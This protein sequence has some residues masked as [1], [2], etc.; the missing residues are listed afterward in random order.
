MQKLEKFHLGLYDVK[1]QFKRYVYDRSQKA[2]ESGDRDRDAVDTVEALQSRQAFMRDKWIESVGGLPDSDHPLNSQ[3]TGSVQGDG[4]RIDK[5]IFESRPST[6]VTC[7]L[8][9]PDGITKPR[10][11]VMFLC[12]HADNAKQYDRYQGVCQRLVAEGLIVLAVDP[13]GQGER[14]SYYDPA[15]GKPEIPAGTGEHDYAGSQCLPLGDG[16]ARY[17]VHD[18]MRA[19]DY[20][21]TLPQVDQARIGVTGNSG[22]GTQTSMLMLCEPRIAA[23]AP[24]TFI[25]NRETYMY[26][27]QAQD[28]EQVWRGM[29]RWGFDHEDIVLAMAPRPVLVLGVT[30]DFFP[31]E[32]TRRTVERTRRFWEMHGIADMPVLEEDRSTHQY[33][34]PLADKAAAFFARHLLTA[35]ERREAAEPVLQPFPQEELN[36]TRSGQVRGDYPDARAVFEE[37]VERLRQLEERLADQPDERRRKEALA[38]LRERVEGSRIATEL[39]PRHLTFP[40]TDGLF[41]ESYIWWSQPGI[42]N[43]GFYFRSPAFVGKKLPVTIALWEQGTR[44]LA[45]KADWIRATCEGGRAVLVL[46]V[47]ADGLCTPHPIN[48]IPLWNWYGTLHKLTAD[49]FWLDDSLAA[50]RVHDIKRAFDMAAQLPDTLPGSTELYSRGRYGFYA[51]LAAAVEDRVSAL[52]IEDG[53]DNVADWVRS[54]HYE[55]HDLLGILLPGMLQ[56]F[57]L[58]D[59]RRWRQS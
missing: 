10:A 13:I 57:D 43:H 55:P 58:P 2:F 56:R 32:G 12:G 21:C 28:A 50:I 48:A 17:F 22:G 46:D 11:A 15:S 27:G 18:A 9:L 34:P 54:R 47:T 20:L 42:F 16:L 3:V 8:Y 26:A 19:I 45:D 36:C 4:Y 6:Y 41:V 33:S 31:I 25:M 1:D 49:L 7:S 52:R 53:P 59:L 40:E 14:L 30:A 39:N 29:T 5:V 24:G 35:E 51:E 38:W 37:N 44:S 23:A